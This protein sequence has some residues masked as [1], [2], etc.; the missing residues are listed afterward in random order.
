[1]NQSDVSEITEGASEIT[2]HV[3]GRLYKQR[4]LIGRVS[5]AARKDDVLHE[6]QPDQGSDD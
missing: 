3:N 2:D 1:M 4:W 6:F 5:F